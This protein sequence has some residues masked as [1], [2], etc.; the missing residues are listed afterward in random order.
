[1]SKSKTT[2]F[3]KIASLPRQH[4]EVPASPKNIKKCLHPKLQ[5]KSKKYKKLSTSKTTKKIQKI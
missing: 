5:K 2:K 3:L 1:M 4:A